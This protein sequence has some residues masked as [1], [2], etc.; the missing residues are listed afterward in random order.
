MKAVAKMKS[1]IFALLLRI[2]GFLASIGFPIWATSTQVTIL[3][4]SCRESML[5]RIGITAGGAAIIVFIV[6]FT[7]WRYLSVWFREKL[8]SHRTLLGFS[9][10]GYV[11]IL[12]AKPL[13]STLEVIFLGLVIGSAVAVIC[14]AFADLMDGG[15]K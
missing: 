5:E 8:K 4:S 9:T 10:I 3:R 1:K 15:N 12:C 13:L 11:M 7:V 2:A 6:G 14:Y